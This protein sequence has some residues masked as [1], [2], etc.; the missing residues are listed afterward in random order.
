MTRQGRRAIPVRRQQPPLNI[1]DQQAKEF[2]ESIESDFYV[3]LVEWSGYANHTFD[4]KDLSI[5]ALV[6]IMECYCM[7]FNTNP[8]QIKTPLDISGIMHVVRSRIS[9]CRQFG[10]KAEQYLGELMCME[11]AELKTAFTP[12]DKL[13]GDKDVQ[14][15]DESPDSNMK[16]S[17]NPERRSK[18]L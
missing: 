16:S 13:I 15:L 14:P 18:F 12:V 2:I 1:Y 4:T 11:Q 17:I 5:L 9:G 10:T 3:E 8:D 7:D 6:S